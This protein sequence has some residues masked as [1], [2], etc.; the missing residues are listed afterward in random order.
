MKPSNNVLR[1]LGHVCKQI[2]SHTQCKS[3]VFFW[4]SFL[5]TEICTFG[6]TMVQIQK[7]VTNSGS[8]GL[9]NNTVTSSM[10]WPEIKHKLAALCASKPFILSERVLVFSRR[11]LTE[12]QNKA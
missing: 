12:S 1:C 10:S 3:K 6:Q 8:K 2:Y 11:L 4:P 7:E 9:T 5:L